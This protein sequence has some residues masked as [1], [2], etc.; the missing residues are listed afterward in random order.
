MDRQNNSVTL[1]CM[2][3]YCL[4]CMLLK[5]RNFEHN[6]MDIDHLYELQYALSEVQ[7]K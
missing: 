1:R 2:W 4:Q 5:L 3:V 7:N 6:D